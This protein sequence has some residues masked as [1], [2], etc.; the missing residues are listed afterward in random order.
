[1]FFNGIGSLKNCPSRPFF[2]PFSTPSPP[3]ASILEAEKCSLGCRGRRTRSPFSFWLSRENSESVYRVR[4]SRARMK[5]FRVRFSLRSRRIALANWRCFSPRALLSKSVKLPSGAEYSSLPPRS[6][7][8]LLHPIAARPL[9]DGRDV[10]QRRRWIWWLADRRIDRTDKTDP[11]GSAK[12]GSA[13]ARC[14]V[15]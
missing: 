10:L 4:L 7:S 14:S 3:I 1:M 5:N 12:S 6:V 2:P 8:P 11:R 15:S 13:L 9:A